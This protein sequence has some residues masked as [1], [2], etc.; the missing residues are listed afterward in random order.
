MSPREGLCLLCGKPSER[1]TTDTNGEDV[2]CSAC[3]HYEVEERAIYDLVSPPD[4]IP[5]S[6][7]F[8]LSGITRGAWDSGR[9]RFK[10]THSNIRELLASAPV[11]KTPF[12]AFDNLITIVNRI[13]PSPIN[14]F[15]V[16]S[17]DDWPLTFSRDVEEFRALVAKAGA[18]GWIETTEQENGLHCTL[19][20]QGWQRLAEIQRAGR[21]TRQTFIAMSFAPEMLEYAVASRSRSKRSRSRASAGSALPVGAP[22]R[23]LRLCW[24][25]GSSRSSIPEA[26]PS[27]TPDPSSPRPCTTSCL[28]PRTGRGAEGAVPYG[29]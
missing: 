2:N 25:R 26:R 18:A 22:P 21:A 24:G 7:L 10:L 27:G 15:V 23:A 5:R 17:L 11:P 8:K 16:F 9:S 14:G 29:H 28:P 19:T 4:S 6:E 3:G 13:S 1:G 20:L 12:E